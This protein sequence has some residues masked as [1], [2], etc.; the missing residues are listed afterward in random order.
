MGSLVK[1]AK[2][3]TAARAQ[4]MKKPGL[5]AGEKGP[6]GMNKRLTA[7]AGTQSPRTAETPLSRTLGGV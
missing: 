5:P 6:G 7:G 1:K 3:N 4:G 2:T